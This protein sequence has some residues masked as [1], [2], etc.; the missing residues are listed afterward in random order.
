MTLTRDY[1]KR[2]G[3]K[4]GI[5]R[6]SKRVQQQQPFSQIPPVVLTTA[7]IFFKLV[8]NFLWFHSAEK[9]SLPHR[10]ISNDSLQVCNDKM[11]CVS[12]DVWQ[13]DRQKLLEYEACS[14]LHRAAS[15][16]LRPLPRHF[17][18]PQKGLLKFGLLD[19]MLMK[20]CSPQ[21]S[22]WLR[23]D[24][25]GATLLLFITV[26]GWCTAPLAGVDRATVKVENRLDVKW[27]LSWH[28]WSKETFPTHSEILKW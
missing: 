23:F 28:F 27:H 4:C 26:P 22:G 16:N 11:L 12:S 13:M 20:L 24:L 25:A 1:C 5:S 15:Y 7:A 8:A 10:A 17:I 21:S 19:L 9:K 18:I 14:H 6:T 3:R 2:V